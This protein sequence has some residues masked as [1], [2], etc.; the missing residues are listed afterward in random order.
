MDI[1]DLDRR[2]L[3]TVDKI[4]SGTTDLGLRTPCTGWTLGDLL[5]HQVSE[6]HGFAVALR[7]GSAADWHSGSL[8]DDPYRAYAD[9]V[10]AFLSAAADD[11][12]LTRE[13]T[14]REF[15]TF[16]GSVALTMH[17]VDSVAHGWDLARTFGVP[18]QPD[19][20]A[21][22]VALRFAERMRARPR[23]DDDVFAPVLEVGPDAGELDRFLALT[24]RDP[25]W[26]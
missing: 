12:V 4:V 13:V 19:A 17:L 9:S 6:N 21:V 3:R 16:P 14:V 18:Y 26:R 24:G 2:V 20:E 22:H 5:I 23:P 7:E 15:G 8:G 11:A 25:A 10:D 1:R